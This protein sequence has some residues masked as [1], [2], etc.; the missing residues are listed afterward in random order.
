[1]TNCRKKIE[2]PAEQYE[3]LLNNKKG[4]I[5][6]KIKNASEFKKGDKITLYHLSWGM[7][8]N[9]V[10]VCKKAFVVDKTDERIILSCSKE[11]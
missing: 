8:D 5:V 4:E 1:M 3:W 6:L 11:K 2:I 10:E 9:D 7:F